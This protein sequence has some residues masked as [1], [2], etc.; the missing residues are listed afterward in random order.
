M[1]GRIPVMDVAPVVELGRYPAKAAVGEPFTVSALVFRE[2]HDQLDADVVLT[3][4]DGKDRAPV[5]MQ[6]VEGDDVD[7]WAATVVC[8]E[9]GPWSFTI[10]AWSDPLATWD[11]D[12]G[13]KVPAGIDVELMFTEG[14]LLLDRVADSL[15]KRGRDR[16]T[17]T[18]AAKALRDTTRPPGAR[19]SAWADPALTA[20]LHAHPLRDLL[21]TEGPYPLFADRSR[22]LVGS[23]YEF[24]P[25]SE[26][27][28]VDPTTGKTVSGTFRT[29][30]ERLHGVAAMGFDVVYLP[31]IHPIGKVNRK[32]PNNTLTPG[33]DDVGS[34]WAIGSDEG[35][36]DAIHPDLGTFD[37]FDA[38]VAR[39]GDLGLEIALDL[40]L[41]AAPDHPWVK[42]N[43]EWFTTRADGSIA[44]AENPPKKYQDIY[45]I[46]FDNDPEG[47]YAEVLRVVRLWMDH[48]VR[49]FRVDNPHTKPVAFWERLLAEIRGTDPDVVFLSEAFTK[50]PMMRALGTVGFHQSYTY[51]T[52]R[53][54]KQ[55]LGDYLTELSQETAHVLRPN[56]FVNT[57]DILHASLQYG[58]PA[59]FKLRAVLAATASP[60][61]GVYAG[62]ELFEHVAVR[63]G[64]EEYLDSE[65]YQIRIRDWESAEAEGRSL[66]PY[67]RRLNEIRRAHP[68]LQQLRNL[69]VHGSDDD[70]IL[71]FSKTDLGD[72]SD[73][74]DTVIVVVNVD[75]H[76]TRETTVHLDLPALGMEWDE[77]FA[78]HDELSGQTWHWSAH[79][80]V[81]LD[82]HHE[83]AHVLTV[84]RTR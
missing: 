83:P 68:A 80:Y 7:R 49:I 15:P 31:P 73:E 10:R 5:R 62:Y 54:G 29:A 1:V 57:P 75:P 11:H 33:P 66:A 76:A 18:D 14:A 63:P 30:A 48:G 41:Q 13:I 3:G 26:G 8:D 65:K 50:P 52:W 16:R 28:Y 2:G 47:I 23:W 81:R 34:P 46:N 38:F 20:V 25:R 35:G 6:R 61:W 24:F 19:L 22:A 67:L 77:G 55:E 37:D 74:R 58:G 36:H 4:P 17:V 79:N 45:P 9:V 70:A 59:A 32:G 44:Y 56:L 12:A 82:P 43:P 51:F 27:A 64:S 53:T 69:H 71:V 21:S 42:S 84:R 78:V 39:A 72:T 60:S 40:A